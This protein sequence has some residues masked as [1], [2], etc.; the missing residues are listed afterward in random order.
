MCPPLPFSTLSNLRCHQYRPHPRSAEFTSSAQHPCSAPALQCLALRTPLR[1]ATI[2]PTNSSAL[3]HRCP[4]LWHI[5][6]PCIGNLLP[7]LP[8]CPGDSV[9]G[10]RLFRS[11]QPRNWRLRRCR[12]RSKRSSRTLQALLP[13]SLSYTPSFSNS[14]NFERSET[15]SVSQPLQ[16]SA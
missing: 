15:F 9:P 4:V 3:A 16:H 13:F 12:V 7:P 14:I 11:D 5:V 10:T 2:R 6:A 8:S 1:C